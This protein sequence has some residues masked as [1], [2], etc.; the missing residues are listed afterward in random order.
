MKPSFLFFMMDQFSAKWF[1]AG[2][3]VPTPNFD[4][5]R[6]TGVTFTNAITSNP[7]CAPARSTLATG[8]SSRAHGVLENGYHL[9]PSLPT[10]M[11]LL[12]KSGWRTGAFGKLHFIPHYETLR[13]DY[14]PYGFDEAAVTEDGRGGPW[15]DWIM[16][17][18]P[19]HA[20]SVLATIWASG[21]EEYSAYGPENENLAERIRRIRQSHDWSS[22]QAPT[23]SALH[24][25][26]PFPPE[27]S[28]TEWITRNAE[29]FVGRL[30]ADQPFLAHVSYV[31]P[32]DPF[33][34]PADRVPRVNAD[35]IPA[36]IGETWR[37]DPNHPS[38]L[39]L[40]TAL[41]PGI[42]ENWRERRM[43]YFADIAH[44]DDQLGRVMRALERAGRLDSTY[45][46]L[47]ADHGEMLFD[48]G[49]TN[50]AGFH[51][52][53]CIRIPLVIA[54][55]GA[56]QGT[57]R[58]QLVQLEDLFPTIT[59]LASLPNPSTP[60]R[61]H[62]QKNPGYLHGTS[63]RPLL[64]GDGSD[65]HRDAA[66]VES[67]SVRDVDYRFWART[68]RTQRY[69]YTWYPNGCGEELFDFED[70]PDEQ[71]NLVGAP[72]RAGL[73]EEM[74]ERLLNEIVRQ[75]YPYSP[76]SLFRIGVH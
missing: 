25:T 5:L 2:D 65:W 9:D 56:E 54:G 18:H 10:F 14:R 17:E 47:L 4:R 64:A 70:D 51:Y 48:H 22:V 45:I 60:Y 57:V 42:P 1:E 63:L 8:L 55:P 29:D 3:V 76:R 26:L 40:P 15:L 49:F 37:A 74:R 28:Q 68:V 61:A 46:V 41:I 21:I 73:R 19:E 35:R 43:L 71:N 59:D 27:L 69:R 39:D 33:C 12:Q 72:S 13:P 66:Y 38:A 44:L 36:P 75:D 11:Q 34:P 23:G 31:Q 30:G 16:S 53:A 67:Y 7:L 58:R 20:E 62:L 24:Y 50:K 52:D 6:A 32:H